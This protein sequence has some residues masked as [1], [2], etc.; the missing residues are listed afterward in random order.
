M[1]LDFLMNN[2]L[3]YYKQHITSL[4]L[5]F[6]QR[7]I[8]SNSI[9]LF[10]KADEYWGLVFEFNEKSTIPCRLGLRSFDEKELMV[11]FRSSSIKRSGVIWLFSTREIGCCG[12]GDLWNV[13]EESVVNGLMFWLLFELLS[14][15][16]CLQ[17]LHPKVLCSTFV[18]QFLNFI[19]CIL[20]TDVECCIVELGNCE[21]LF[22]FNKKFTWLGEDSSCN[23]L[24]DES[25]VN[26]SR[27]VLTALIFCN[28]FE[29]CRENITSL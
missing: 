19:F 2:L 27:D 26:E 29:F 5:A 13:Y 21:R 8:L 24:W 22:P 4:T 25:A 6:A 18:N 11:K 9:I 3:R 1:H 15:F 16:L 28:E 23:L 12:W 20:F 10:A 17:D 14:I 7:G